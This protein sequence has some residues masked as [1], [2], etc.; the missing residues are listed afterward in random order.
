[1]PSL[2]FFQFGRIYFLKFFSINQGNKATW[3][4]NFKGLILCLQKPFLS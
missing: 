2:N 1:M 3:I 4:K